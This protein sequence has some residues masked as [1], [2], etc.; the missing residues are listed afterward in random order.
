MRTIFRMA[1]QAFQDARQRRA[2][3]EALE[4]LDERALRD[5]GFET[6]ANSRRESLRSAMRF[7]MY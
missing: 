1:W 4:H 5:I 6:E 3:T 7:G 2:D